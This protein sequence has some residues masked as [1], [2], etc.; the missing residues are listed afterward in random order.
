[1]S[2]VS[3]RGLVKRFSGRLAV[4]GVDLELPFG[5]VLGLLGPNGA[6]K[7]TTLRMLAG[8]LLPDAGVIEVCGQ[9]LSAGA[10]ARREI[11]FL[12]AGMA[13][14]DNLT[15]AENLEYFGRLRGMNAEG[16]RRRPAELARDLGM[17]AVLDQRFSTLSTGQRQKA[18]IAATILHDPRVLI[19]DEITASL[20]V[21]AASTLI[22]FVR[23]EKAAG[24]CVVFSTHIISEAEYLCDEIA[25]IH[26]GK[27]RDRGTAAELVE[28]YGS[29]NL[30]EAFLRS[31]LRR[32]AA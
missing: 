8:L 28:R 14:Y 18:L 23:K 7:T 26:E 11:G 13:L 31:V 27:V 2:A 3:A 9:S 24:K 6:G 17:E 12:S 20:D 10:A 16:M 25:I 19:L 21:I 29:R 22:D 4:D 15:V 32:E 5:H 30:T 1:M